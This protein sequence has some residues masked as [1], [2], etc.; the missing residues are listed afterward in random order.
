MNNRAGDADFGPRPTD[1]GD[2]DRRPLSSARQ[3]VL[4]TLQENP[5]PMTLAELSEATSLHVNTLREHLQALREQGRVTRRPARPS[6]RGRPAWRYES[7]PSVRDD[8]QY[9]Y[10][11]LAATLAGVIHQLST[12]PRADGID[13]GRAWGRSLA[14]HHQSSA[15]GDEAG[16]RR[17][18]LAVLTDLGFAPEANAPMTSVRLPQCPLL[19][20]ARSQPDV[21]CAVHLGIVR[22]ALEAWGTTTHDVE[23]LAF[24]EPGA[25]R[26]LLAEEQ[27]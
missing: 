26:L 1:F 11:A 13:A 24:S 16:S 18:L 10:A 5:S 7:T 17:Q 6:G 15:E 23:L 20:A 4:T 12:D 22:G 19:T 9:A 8:G 3:F 2:A 25:C 27:S 21:V 14:Q